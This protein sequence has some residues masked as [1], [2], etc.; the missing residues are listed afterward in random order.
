M[1][2]FFARANRFA[3]AKHLINRQAKEQE[4]KE[5]DERQFF[6][7]VRACE[8]KLYNTARMLLPCQAD[9]EDAVQEALFKAWARLDSL[10]DTGRFEA[11]LMRILINEC[12][13]LLRCCGERHANILST[14]SLTCRTG[15][16]ASR[17]TV[18]KGYYDGE[19]ARTVVEIAPV[20]TEFCAIGMPA[21][22]DSR[23]NGARYPFLCGRTPR[24]VARCPLS[25]ILQRMISP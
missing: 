17:L 20:R 15:E 12:K 1:E 13:M 5:L 23:R 18:R 19:M 9:C 25:R 10:R 2:E 21:S 4:A 16:Y 8:Q 6:Q 11:W 14:T 3:R 7:R 24:W 22:M